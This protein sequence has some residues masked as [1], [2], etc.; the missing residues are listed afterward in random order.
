MLLVIRVRLPPVELLIGQDQGQ[1][2][3]LLLS[4]YDQINERGTYLF[5]PPDRRLR[6]D[7]GTRWRMRLGVR[8]GF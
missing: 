1:P 6:D 4:G 5:F 3:L 2:Q 8:Y 7:E